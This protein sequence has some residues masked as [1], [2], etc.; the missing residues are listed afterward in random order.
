MASDIKIDHSSGNQPYLKITQ[1]REGNSSRPKYLINIFENE[2][3]GL[4][5]CIEVNDP[6]DKP[7][8]LIQIALKMAKD[9]NFGFG[10][11]NR[12]YRWTG[13]HWVQCEQWF[14]ALGFGL[15]AAIRASGLTNSAESLYGIT[16][17]V[18]H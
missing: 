15:Y 18:C 16:C 1:D 7:S 14:D 10:R 2:D 17:V 5:Y 6:L 8:F 11:D 4:L 13:S 3:T 9:P 12:P